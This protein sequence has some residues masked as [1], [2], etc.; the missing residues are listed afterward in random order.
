MDRNEKENL[1][2]V[3]LF[4]VCLGAVLISAAP[5]AFAA[6]A[7]KTSSGTMVIVFKDGHKQVVNLADVERVEYPLVDVQAAGGEAGPSRG[8]FLGKWDCGDGSGGNFFITLLENGDAERSIGNV[9]GRWVYANGEADI[10]WDDG[11]E[12]ALRRVGTKW[13]KFAYSSGKRFTDAPANV[14]NARNTTQ[15]PI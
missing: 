2:R 15:K 9:H 8:R 7:A 3:S 5:H 11:A 10:T 1:M 4:A 14:T 13:Q 6:P 12:D